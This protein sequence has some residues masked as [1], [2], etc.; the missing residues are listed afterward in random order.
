MAG[1]GW[2]GG[3]GDGEGEEEGKK[4]VGKEEEEKNWKTPKL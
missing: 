2:V 3:R 4:K 1:G